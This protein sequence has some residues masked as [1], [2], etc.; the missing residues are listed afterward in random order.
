MYLKRVY[1]A[2]QQTNAVYAM[3]M[4]L[5]RDNVIRDNVQSQLTTALLNMIRRER[6][7]E[8]IDRLVFTIFAPTPV[9]PDRS[10]LDGLHDAR[11]SGQWIV[12]HI[13]VDL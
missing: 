10:S 4:R 9:R 13:R 7:G 11:Q 12:G 8:A 6:A 2:Q 3:S 1:A 5:F